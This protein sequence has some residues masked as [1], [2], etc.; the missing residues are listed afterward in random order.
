[1]CLSFVQDICRR[2]RIDENGKKM[3]KTIDG[4]MGVVNDFG[5]SA[6]DESIFVCC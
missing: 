5:P 1:M 2:S 6:K 3:C 4:L